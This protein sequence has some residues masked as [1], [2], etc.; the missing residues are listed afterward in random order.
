M[1]SPAIQLSSVSLCDGGLLLEST[2]YFKTK[3][4]YSAIFIM[5][6]PSKSNIGNTEMT[7]IAPASR[8]SQDQVNKYTT[9]CQML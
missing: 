7:N 9:L 6:L 4:I 3:F 5:Y 1:V 8:D 2:K